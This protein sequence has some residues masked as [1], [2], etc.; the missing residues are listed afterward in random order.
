MRKEKEL[1][2]KLEFYNMKLIRYKG[3]SYDRIG[4]S[5]SRSS[6]DSELLYWLDKIDLVEKQIKRYSNIILKYNDFKKSVG[7]KEALTLDE[8][9]SG[10]VHNKS[11]RIDVNKIVRSWYKTLG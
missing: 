1:Q 2:E 5:G 7:I 9:I 6:G 11:N 3:V 8:W 4:S 10:V